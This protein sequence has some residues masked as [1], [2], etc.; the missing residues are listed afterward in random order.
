MKYKQCH[1][2][3]GESQQTVWLEAE[4]V[5]EGIKVTLK[6]SD[7]P[8]RWWTIVRVY[9]TAL[10]KSEIKDAHAARKWYQNDLKRGTIKG[11]NVFK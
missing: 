9:E 7:E 10:E 3:S 6:D 5:K 8:K 4:K 11:L 2:R 1:V